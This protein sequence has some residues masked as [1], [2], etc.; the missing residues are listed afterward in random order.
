MTETIE[1]M[2][3]AKCSDKEK[4]VRYLMGKKSIAVKDIIDNA[5]ASLL[6]VYPILFELQLENKLMVEEEE[7]LGSPKVVSLVESVMPKN[8]FSVEFQEKMLELAASNPRKR[9][10]YNLHDSLKA[11]AQRLLYAMQPET[12]FPI[13][14]HRDTEET[15]MLLIGSVDI[16]FYDNAGQEEFRVLMNKEDGEPGYV[17][18]KYAYHSLEVKEPSVILLVKDGPY[19]P[20]AE[21]DV[22]FCNKK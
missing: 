22:L 3:C 1:N 21:Q 14:R 12:E 20:S 18:P 17:M 2:P 5:G 8:P 15:Y 9:W 13:H 19:E 6:R 11:P 4:I 10:N 7:E 16:V